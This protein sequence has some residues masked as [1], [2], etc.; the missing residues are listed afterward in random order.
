MFNQPI[1]IN[2]KN[3][4]LILYVVILGVFGPAIY[5]I[6]NSESQLPF[7][8]KAANDSLQGRISLGDKIL[9]KA[10]NNSAK[11]MGTEAYGK[12]DYLAAQENFGMALKSDRNDPEARIYLNN[13]TAAKTK[14]P[15]QIGVSVP[16]G[17]DLGVA[18]EILRGVAQAQTEI[19]SKGGI[20]GKLLMV[21]IANDDNNAELGKEIANKFVA[22]NKL[23]AVI[24][25]NSSNVSMAAAPIYEE[26]GVVMITPT[27]SAETLSNM[28]NHIFR[29]VPNTRALADSLADYAL[30]TARKTNI[31]VCLDSD[32]EASVSFKQNFTWA[33]YNYGGKIARLNCDFAA[34]DFNGANIPSQAI[35]QGID[36]L[37]LAPSVRK[38]DK[39]IEVVNANDDRLTL[40]GNHSLN[41]YST[42]KEGQNGVNGMVL[43]VAWYPQSNDSNFMQEAKELW[44]GGVN[45]RTAMAYD[46]TQ[47]VS[48]AISTGANRENLQQALT[49]PE[50]SADGA[51]TDIT[52][53]PSGDRNLK[54]TLIKIQPGENSGTGYDFVS[55]GGDRASTTA[56]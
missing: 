23:L 35:S 55:L 38:V 5:L 20:D 8:K 50:F 19:N 26:A 53:L 43:S 18:E 30:N 37:L 49:H 41:T 3:F 13:A 7:I 6:S 34:A 40:L 15:H 36:T 48:K 25:H 14:S 42:L 2:Q 16:I 31:G 46:A 39:A 45:W 52:F 10:H 29:T 21:K 4:L 9:V 27:S 24:G 44:G 28:G 56:K 22:D 51:S 11:Q 47:T 1:N 33:V 32:A 12:G 54:G 17:G